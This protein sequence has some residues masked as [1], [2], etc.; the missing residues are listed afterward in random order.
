VPELIGFLVISAGL[1]YLSRASLRHPQSHGFYRFF[2][3]EC[4][5]ILC[6]L[7]LRRWFLNPWSAPQILSWLLLLISAGLVIHG[8][9]LLRRRG[10][11]QRARDDVALLGFERTTVLVTEGAYRYIRHPLYSSLFFLGW[12][13]FFK[14]LT[15]LGGVLASAATVFLVITARI[16]E[17]ENLRFFGAAY[18]AYIHHTK[19][20][21]PFVF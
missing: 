13:I 14:D 1:V 6:L 2:A 7:N 3:W 10:R 8:I 19:M 20:F 15:W 4:L 17:V 12:G 18:Q 5:L 16:E 21:I 9:A 11:P